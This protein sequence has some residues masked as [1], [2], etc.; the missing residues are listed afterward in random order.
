MVWPHRKR[1][2]VTGRDLCPRGE[3]LGTVLHKTAS[4][5]PCQTEGGLTQRTSARLLYDGNDA[6][7]HN[8]VR[9]PSC[10]GHRSL[11][12]VATRFLCGQP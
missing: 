2:A 12:A 1:A 8:K 6:V 11:P 9:K 10:R 4:S 3:G 7:L 5:H